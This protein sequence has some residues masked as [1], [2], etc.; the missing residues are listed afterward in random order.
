MELLNNQHTVLKF[1]ILNNATAATAA[2]FIYKYLYLH[3][4]IIIFSSRI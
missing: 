3:D 2:I 4:N 1:Y